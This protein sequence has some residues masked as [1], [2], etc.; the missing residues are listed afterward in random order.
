MALK[1][2]RGDTYRIPFE[3]RSRDYTYAKKVAGGVL[4]FLDSVTGKPEPFK[5]SVLV[6]LIA[7]KAAT[8]VQS[9]NWVD[10][11]DVH[12]LMDATAPNTPAETRKKIER[13]QAKIAEA[14][15][16]LFYAKRLDAAAPPVAES[17][18]GLEL[19]IEQTYK[20]AVCSGHF[21]KP[22][23]S[24]LYRALQKGIPGERFLADLISKRGE[25]TKRTWKDPWVKTKLKEAVDHYYS[26]G[27]PQP[28]QLQEVVITFLG[29][30]IEE[31]EARIAQGL[32]HLKY[33]K[34]TAVENHIRGEET[35]ARLAKRDPIL[36]LKRYGGK[37]EGAIAERPLQHVQVDQTQIDEWVNIYDED[38]NI[39]DRKR[40]YLVS[41]ID[42]Y[43]RMILAAVLTFEDPSTY[44]VQLAIK[45]M[46]RPKL[47]LIE[48]F[49]R[50]KGS[51]D[52]SGQPEEMTFDNGV[53]NIGFSMRT[54]L[55]D[56]G[57]D[58]SVAPRAT[59]EA[60]AIVERAFQ[61]YNQGVWHNAPGGIPFKPHALSARRLKPQEKAEWALEF[62]TGV[63]WYW[64][65]NVYHFNRNRTLEAIPVRLWSEKV[66]DPM[67]GRAVS[68]RLDLV[69]ILCG[70]RVRL[71][72]DG[73]G[74]RYKTH[75]FHHQK[76]TENFLLATLPLERRSN[77][78]KVDIEAII[79]PHDCSFI[80]IVDNVRNR[81]V[82]LP[83]SKPNFSDG[84]SYAEAALIKESERL[85][86]RQFISEEE[87]ILAKYNY[88]KLIDGARAQARTERA[89]KQ[90]QR[91][92][93]KARDEELVVWTLVD[94]D[95]IELGTI[96]PSV[97]G[98][99]AY[100]VPKEMASMQRNAAL[101][102]HKDQPRNAAKSRE[103][104]EINMRIKELR[105][106]N[107]PVPAESSP[108][109]AIKPPIPVIDNPVS[110]LEQLAYDLD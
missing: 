20:S 89:L 1:L 64:I 87:L 27:N 103:T 23:N 75:T 62:A 55:G 74:V 70:T 35:Q 108:V 91:A 72:I 38:G 67:V 102:P 18:A 40:P 50:K 95:H 104:R 61:T 106:P 71:K 11:I 59:P 32:N 88:F 66:N 100:D 15:M 57:V 77:R 36:A 83:N 82:R 47:F 16:L 31:D 14:A 98:D 7:E 110:F 42:V 21:H 53:E 39:E 80:T 46:L 107:M 81:L 76:V 105:A 97:R 34:R 30:A 65:V 19:F 45:Q 22:S 25:H 73:A 93:K 44:T 33:P 94:G 58:V 60:K 5:E 43:S 96:E 69:D 29:K 48:R 37:A 56:A 85:L 6:K 13:A 51:T 12:A 49:G 68:K 3:G 26:E 17:K 99:A 92:K 84:L 78:G 10:R 9:S 8:P 28:P 2:S 24:A 90:A 101:K 109:P 4:V 63:M 54:L 79:Y 41:I 52:G 86:D